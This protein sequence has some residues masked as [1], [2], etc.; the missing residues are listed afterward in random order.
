M[1]RRIASPFL[2]LEILEIEACPGHDAPGF[3]AR[4]SFLTSSYEEEQSGPR[5][6]SL[7]HRS[8]LNPKK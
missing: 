8:L 6:T 2:Y 7:R 3:V 4:T 1:L 5:I